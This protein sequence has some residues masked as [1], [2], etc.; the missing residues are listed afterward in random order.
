M[1]T[2]F[3]LYFKAYGIVLGNTCI[4]DGTPTLNKSVLL[5]TRIKEP[6]NPM[7]NECLCDKS[8]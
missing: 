4:Y 6:I 3:L 5:A 1:H 8:V 7:I 2:I